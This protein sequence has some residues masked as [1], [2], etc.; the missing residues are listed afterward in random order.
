MNPEEAMLFAEK[1]KQGW[2]EFFKSSKQF[3]QEYI[4][5]INSVKSVAP[6]FG[7]L[8]PEGYNMYRYWELNGKPKNW[9]EAL[10][11]EMFHKQK[12]GYHA[13]T[14]A[15]NENGEG[16][17]M[18]HKTFP[19][20]W[21]EKAFYDGY[22]FLTDPETE[23]PLFFDRMPEY[24]GVHPILIPL[25]GEKAE[26]SKKFRETYDLIED[27]NGNRKYVPKKKEAEK[28]AKGGA[29]NIIPEGELHARLHHME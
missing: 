6:N 24:E 22:D 27:E 15:W 12:D 21:M 25:R 18:K 16:E 13:H 5:F 10:Q 11:K 7:E 19:T 14:I 23:E 26:E 4:D 20:A 9:D 28:F 8:E 2:P 17:W 29:M 3:P 1:Y